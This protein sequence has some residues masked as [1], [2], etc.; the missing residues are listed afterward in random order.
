MDI[1]E[2]LP[3]AVDAAIFAAAMVLV[4]VNAVIV[5]GHFPRQTRPLS[6]DVGLCVIVVA[7]TALF[8]SSV[9]LAIEVMPWFAIVIFAG[10]AVLFA[11][12]IEQ[13]LP[14]SW[15]RCAPGLICISACTF[16]LTTMTLRTLGY[17]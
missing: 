13:Q 14:I 8:A 6:V 1:L 10:L 15:R 11:P 7:T 2:E 17:I 4:F 12:L 5:T 3:N 9:I 16:A